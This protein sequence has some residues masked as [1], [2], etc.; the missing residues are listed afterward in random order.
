MARSTASPFP[1]YFAIASLL[2][3]EQTLVSQSVREFAARELAP[4]ITQNFSRE[5]FPEKAIPVRTK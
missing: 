3:E 4:S 1:D 5:E 2:N